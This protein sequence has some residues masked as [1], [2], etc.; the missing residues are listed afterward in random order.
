MRMG[1]RW[2]EVEVKEGRGIRN[3]GGGGGE[4][5]E[6]GGVKGRRGRKRFFTFKGRKR[7]EGRKLFSVQKEWKEEEKLVR[8]EGR[9]G[10]VCRTGGGVRRA[11]N[12]PEGGE[13]SVQRVSSIP[14][15]KFDQQY[16]QVCKYSLQC[17]Y[18]Y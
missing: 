8:G 9:G 7:G 16:Y 14:L 6:G 5:E 3:R 10:R 13:E 4:R 17:T 11:P 1:K 12:M 2:E 18:I 15:Y